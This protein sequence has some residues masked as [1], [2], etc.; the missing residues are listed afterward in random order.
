MAT[1]EKELSLVLDDEQK[2]LQQ[3]ASEFFAEHSPVDRV[4]KLRDTKDAVGYSKALWKQMA[5]LGFVGMNIPEADGG[6]G[7]GFFELALVLEEAGR[8]L[9]PEPFVS[10]VLLGA[11]AVLTA[12]SDAQRQAW[13]PGIASGELVLTVGYVEP[14]SRFDVSKIETRA[15]RTAGGHR[16]VG[17]KVQVLDAQVADGIVVSARTKEGVSLFLVDPNAPGVKVVPQ[18]RLDGRNVAIVELEGVEVPDGAVLGKEGDGDRI[19]SHVLDVAAIGLAAEMLGAAEQ[20]FEDTVAYLKVRKQFGVPIGS[21]QA[22][23]HRAARLF[24]EIALLRSSVL[25]AARAVDARPSEVAKLASLAKARANDTLIHVTN[26]AVQMHGGVGVTDECNVGFYV[27]RARACEA[28]F[29][30]SAWHRARW[31]MLNGY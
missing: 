13:L 1:D 20:A 2:M 3:T 30:D 23:Q 24:T 12:G 19:L 5:E 21:F 14:A 25:A 31:A 27:K 26:E 17:R 18:Q 16:L 10:T 15:E 11:Q 7:L 9:S 29:G 28:T 8:R 4:R 6:T 22:L